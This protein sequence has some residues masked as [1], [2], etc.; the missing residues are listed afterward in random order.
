M[1]PNCQAVCLTGGGL[2][3]DHNPRVSAA[4]ALSLYRYAETC[5]VIDPK[6]QSWNTSKNLGQFFFITKSFLMFITEVRVYGL[7]KIEVVKEGRRGE[8]DAS[9]AGVEDQ[10]HEARTARLQNAHFL[11]QLCAA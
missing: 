4:H 9:P 5:S 3:N 7:P 10:G 6:V 1:L 2:H 11:P 8:A